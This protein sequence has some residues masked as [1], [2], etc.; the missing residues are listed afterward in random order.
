MS[1]FA[2]LSDLDGVLVDSTASVER[3]W[4]QWARE[5]GIDYAELEHHLHGVPS[6]QTIARFAPHL[7]VAAESTRL[8]DMQADDTDGCVALPGAADLL[9]GVHGLPSRSSPRATSGSR[10]RASAPPDSRRRRSS[11]RRIR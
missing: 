6:R 9:A 4:G 5:N 7:D 11:S 2:L 10:T 8:D 3:A 1:G